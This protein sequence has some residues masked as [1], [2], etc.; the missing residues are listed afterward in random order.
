PGHG[1]PRYRVEPGGISCVCV[2]ELRN[3]GGRPARPEFVPGA[4]YHPEML[5]VSTYGAFWRRHLLNDDYVLL[6]WTE[7]VRRRE[8]WIRDAGGAESVFL[9]PN[10]CEKIFTGQEPRSTTGI[11][12]S[13]AW[14]A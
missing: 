10:S 1:A 3:R 14:K 4:L 11:T 5:K 7:F 8:I 2:I 9:R 6:P 12:R 13:G